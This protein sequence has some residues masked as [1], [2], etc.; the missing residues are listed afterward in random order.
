[1]AVGTPTYMSPEQALGQDVDARGDI[2]ALGCMVFEM[3]AGQPPFTGRNVQSI[4][5]QHVTAPVPAVSTIRP[6]VPPHVDAAVRRAMAKIPA[7]RFTTA[8]DFERALQG[9]PTST[10]A[11]LSVAMAR[12]LP[13]V[14][15]IY[16]TVAIGAFFVLEVLVGRLVWSPYLPMFG[17]IALLS[18]LPAVLA[19]RYRPSAGRI[20]VPVNVAAAALILWL[21]FGGKDL[22]A[23][24]KSVVV[25]DE[26]GNR[27]E[28]VV[29]KSEFRKRFAL[30]FFD[31]ASGQADLDWLQYG[32]P[33]AIDLDLEQDLFVQTATPDEKMEEIRE[34]GYA[35]GA[36]TCRSPC[37]EASP[38]TYITRTS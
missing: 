15:G 25:E 30:F 27:V 21:G 1:M 23:A 10:S 28:R 2:Y 33:L 4:V 14:A 24:T 16:G 13:H 17:L 26:D 7:D 11:F 32:L 9:R 31:N 6:S 37:S 5:Q 29:P 12:K 38:K 20:V 22:G 34:A 3:L 36:R 19:V 8:M 35:S 18:L